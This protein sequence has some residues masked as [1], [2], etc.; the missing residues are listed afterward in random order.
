MR[1]LFCIF[2]LLLILAG[3]GDKNLH[4]TTLNTTAAIPATTQA[5]E[6]GTTGT[7]PTVPQT[8][9][10]ETEPPEPS[11]PWIEEVGIP[12]DAEGALLE[13]PLTIPNGMIYGSY[14]IYDADLLLW[15]QDDH[16]LDQPRTQLC[17]VDLENGKVLAQADIPI[18]VTNLPQVL[19]EW[20]YL[21]DGNSGLI[22][23]LDKELNT[24]Q[25]W[26]TQLKECSVY[27]SPENIAYV[28]PWMEDPYALDLET[29][30][31]K[32]VLEEE[33]AIS[34]LFYQNGCVWVDYYHVE[35]GEN[36]LAMIDLITAERRDPSE[37]GVDSAQYCDGTWLTSEYDEFPVYTLTPE[38]GQPVVLQGDYATLQLL[39]K[40]LLLRISEEGQHLSSH[41]L[42]GKNLAECTVYEYAYGYEFFEMFPS[43][44][45]GG[46]FVVIGSYDRGIRLLH[47]DLT[48]SEPGEDISFESL[49]EPTEMEAQVQSRVEALEVEYGLNI[50][51]GL[52]T[53]VYFA[54]F[55]VAQVTDWEDVMLG[56][57]ILEDALDAF[58]EGFFRQ[59]RYDDFH[60]TE[61]HLAGSLTAINEEYTDTYVAFVQ[62]Q[63][64]C[65]VMVVDI[66]LADVGTY[67]HEFSHIIDGFLEWDAMERPDALFSEETWCSLNP[68]W[69]AGYTYTYAWEQYL[70]DYTSFIDSYSTIYPTEDR[71]RILEYAMQDFGQ[72]Y[73]ENG[74]ILMVKLEYYCR[75]IRDAFDTS[76]WPDM[77][78][79]EQFLP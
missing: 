35:T 37:R 22:L 66:Y 38:D 2:I 78:L 39:E 60:R 49:P 15:T 41:D 73:F 5:T 71:A 36:C 6:P 40:N 24:V 54:D 51:V 10:P 11:I 62:E 45:L 34:Y 70:E 65:H 42:S 69:F 64:D 18:Y 72:Y 56:L 53:E 4:T 20:L 33:P 3:C 13:L 47:W 77:V 29:G 68:S 75:C 76:T 16:R 57:D 23:Q 14:M 67:Y 55:E 21:F 32:A 31:R 59:L 61:I 12:W 9:A 30:E 28:D 79:W 50:L 25:Q 8:T 26:D 19:E 7:I 74:T 27:M 1:R 44:S 48:K 58:P 46:Y 17:L 52:E 63:F 43:E